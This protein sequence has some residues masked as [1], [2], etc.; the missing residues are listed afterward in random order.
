M[1]TRNSTAPARAP[2][3]D[4]VNVE[5]P[6]L[7]G[8]TVT[9]A[10]WG[11]LASFLL[12]IVLSATI[13]SVT[14]LWQAPLLMLLAGPILVLWFG[15]QHLARIKRGRPDG[16]Y[17]QA[18]NL[19]LSRRGLAMPHFL[20]HDGWFSLGREAGFS[21]TSRL[22]P[23]VESFPETGNLPLENTHE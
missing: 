5:P 21:L 18:L 3:T 4:R 15:S 12:F 1:N 19:W 10:K 20:I 23:P 13:F 9:E 16:F 17:G 14:G 7:H 22:H 8:M 6:I 2:L 11:A